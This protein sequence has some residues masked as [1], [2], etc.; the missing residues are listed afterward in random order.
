MVGSDVVDGVSSDFAR[1]DDD[2]A[3]E[4]AVQIGLNAE[5][6]V[7]ECLVAWLS[8]GRA[9]LRLADDSIWPVI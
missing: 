2:V 1:V 4:S 8:G 5:I 7:G 6:E 3:R 9:C